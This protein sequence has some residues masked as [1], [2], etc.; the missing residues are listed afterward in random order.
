MVNDFIF[1]TRRKK[2]V[3]Y[4][5]NYVNDSIG[6]EDFEITFL[7]LLWKSMKEDKALQINL[8]ELKNFELDPKSDGFSSLVT[9]VF[10]QFEILE[11]EE[12]TE[13]EVKNYVRG[14][15]Q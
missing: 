10:R 4:I 8:K 3:L 6:F 14:I 5:E 11:N 13:Q 7:Q 1:W 12:C 9:S 2:F 15:L